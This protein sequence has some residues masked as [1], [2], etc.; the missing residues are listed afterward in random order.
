MKDLLI[1][2]LLCTAPVIIAEIGAVFRDER[3]RKLDR[4]KR[5]EA[6][7]RRLDELEKWRHS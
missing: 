1:P 6:I 7:E 4:S 2:L 3:A 5:F